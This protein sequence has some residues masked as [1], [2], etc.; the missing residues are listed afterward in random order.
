MAR[1]RGHRKG[2]WH[3]HSKAHAAAARKGHRKK[4]ARRRR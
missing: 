3:G 1:K 4:K 2:G